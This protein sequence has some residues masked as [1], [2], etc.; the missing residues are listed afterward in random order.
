MT[1]MRY[2]LWLLCREF[3]FLISSVYI[4]WQ[5]IS[6]LN[7]LLYDTDYY[8]DERTTMFVKLNPFMVLIIPES[9]HN[10]DCATMNW[11]VTTTNGCH[12]FF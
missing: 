8:I 10:S 7:L 9:S 1:Q 3:E 4:G 12:W 11:T 5:V 6:D 2:L